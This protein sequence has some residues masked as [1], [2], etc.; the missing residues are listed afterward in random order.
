MRITGFLLIAFIAVSATTT[1]VHA[2]DA[3][4]TEEMGGEESSDVVEE[5]N[6]VW[7]FL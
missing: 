5:V 2:E 6:V 3:V 7:V 4:S 1:L